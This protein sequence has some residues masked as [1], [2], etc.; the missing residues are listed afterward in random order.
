MTLKFGCQTYTWQMSYEKYKDKVSDILDSIQKAGF[1][2][3]EAEVCML[4][5]Y[6]NSPERL[7]EALQSRNLQLAALTLALPW[8]N[9]K[10]TEDEKQEAN[11]LLNYLSYFPEAR[12]ILV[13]LPGKDRSNLLERQRNC[14]KCV[15]TVAERAHNLG[16]INTYHP[17]SPNGSVFRTAEDYDVMFAGLDTRYVGYCPDSGHIA[18]GG[19]DVMKVFQTSR[20]LIKHVHF[21]DI[22]GKKE[23]RTMGEGIIDH[24]GIVNFLRK[25]SYDG[26][27]LVEEES[28]WSKSNPNAAAIKNGQYVQRY[29]Q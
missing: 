16:I 13:Q 3:V 8:Q 14:L 5:P 4:G 19:M 27:I 25:T 1:Q 20:S 29:L 9:G 11:H 10:E 21:K 28:T 23:W 17:N 12:L 26:W 24:T 15:N 6:S 7:V 22:S 18:N 2:G